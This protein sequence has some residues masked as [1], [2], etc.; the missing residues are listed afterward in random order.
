MSKQRPEPKSKKEIRVKLP[1]VLGIRPLYYVPALYIIIISLIVFSL[2]IKPGLKKN[3]TWFDV[4]SIP[5]TAEV[6]VDGSRAGSTPC[7]IF[8]A[9]GN[10]VI[11]VRKPGFSTSQEETDV[12]GR[13][14][15]SRFF[16]RRGTLVISLIPDNLEALIEARQNDFAAWGLSGRPEKNHFLP[17]LWT[18]TAGDCYRWAPTDKAESLSANNRYEEALIGS[19]PFAGNTILLS[20]LIRGYLV[21]SA[22]GG[23]LTVQALLHLISGADR[24]IVNNTN[25]TAWWLDSILAENGTINPATAAWSD[26]YKNYG[27][28][29]QSAKNVLT[30]N[31]GDKAMTVNGFRF[32]YRNGGTFTSGDPEQDL[33]GNP[34]QTGSLLHETRCLPHYFMA[35]EV[36]LS[37]YREFLSEKPEW[38]ADNK[39]TL[40][41]KGLADEGYL[42]EIETA[43]DSDPAVW[44]SW[45]AA[46]A[47]CKWFTEKHLSGTGYK[48]GLP[49]ETEWEYSALTTGFPGQVWE[50]CSTGFAPYGYIYPD[51]EYGWSPE[52]VVRGGCRMNEPGSIKTYT[53]A[54]QPKMLCSPFTGFR[55]VLRPEQ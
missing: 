24:L 2:F 32:N 26:F 1:V 44:V 4:E 13:I 18:M 29:R 53:R 37:L 34:P 39:G 28:I 6:F 41:A 5:G 36:P 51:L 55:M 23:P 38:A 31:P 3:G 7:R 49:T 46:D 11:E 25:G 30:G 40:I 8:I 15:L 50:W 42:Q 33:P 16:P 20:D 9:K 47:F 17:H 54:G 19:I 43:R 12:K 52:A 45:Y 27:E 14:F 35:D 48:A 10:R 21:H 22:K